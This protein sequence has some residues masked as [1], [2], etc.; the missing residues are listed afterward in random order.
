L[1]EGKELG[2]EEDKCVGRWALLCAQEISGNGGF[3]VRD[4]NFNNKIE[5]SSL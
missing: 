4:E 2:S 5:N 3:N 1:S